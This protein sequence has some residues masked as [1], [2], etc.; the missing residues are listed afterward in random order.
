MRYKKTDVPIDKIGREVAVLVHEAKAP[1]SYEVI[2][3]ANDLPSGVNLYP[4]PA[5]SFAR[6]QRTI[7]LR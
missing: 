2:F 3:A 5:G 7:L 4:L 6:A 1:G